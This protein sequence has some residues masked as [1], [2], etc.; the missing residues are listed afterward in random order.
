M[1]ARIA[2]SLLRGSPESARAYAAV[3]KQTATSWKA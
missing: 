2:I 1:S 3:L